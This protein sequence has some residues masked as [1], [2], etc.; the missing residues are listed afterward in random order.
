MTDYLKSNNIIEEKIHIGDIP[1]ILFRPKEKEALLA[2]IIF[3][4]GWSSSKESQRMRGFILASVGYQVIIPDAI[5]HGE[6]NPIEY[7]AENARYFWDVILN[8]FDESELIIKELIEKYKADP[9]RIGLAGHSMGGFISSGVFTHNAKAK[10]LVVFNGSCGWKNSNDI[11]KEEMNITMNEELKVMEDKINL[12]DPSNN[13]HLLRD[14]PILM[15]HGTND[16]VVSVESQR[17]FYS[18]IK[19]LYQDP[20]KVELIEY[21]NLNHY[22][23]TNM[24]EES[25]A[26]FYKYL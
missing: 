10:A 11:F 9:N 24:M 20:K 22:L 7:T 21:P 5:Y 17:N 14:R 12:I 4:H 8:T 1:A 18:S 19:S 2:T 16:N 6:R 15:L 26:W 3:Y 25:I 23:T 13:M